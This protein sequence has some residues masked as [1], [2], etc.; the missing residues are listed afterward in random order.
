MRTRFR[1][2][3]CSSCST[4][5]FAGECGHGRVE[6]PPATLVRESAI[7]EHHSWSTLWRGLVR[8][9]RELVLPPVVGWREYKMDSNG[10]MQA[11]PI[12]SCSCSVLCTNLCPCDCHKARP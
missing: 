2:V 3:W 11:V 6:A 10:N 4:M 5:Q 8:A 9:A 7:A 1:K 12:R